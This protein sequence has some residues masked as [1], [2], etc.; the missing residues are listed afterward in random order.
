MRNSKFFFFLENRLV[1]KTK[2][3]TYHL[4]VTFNYFDK[5]AAINISSQSL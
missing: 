4:F 3:Q 5:G 1:K 2:K